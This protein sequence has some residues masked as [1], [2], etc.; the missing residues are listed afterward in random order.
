[1]I[2]A[3]REGDG[4]GAEDEDDGEVCMIWGCKKR[5]L[6]CFGLKTDV[7]S[8]VGC[9]ESAHVICAGCLVR[10]WEAQNKIHAA[11]GNSS[12]NVRKSCPCCRCE[13]RQTGETRADSEHYHMGLLKVEGTWD[14]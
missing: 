14:D 3:A 11:A 6:R 12:V 13:L 8:A 1:M 5:L 2:A 7:G 10:W 9:A 4:S